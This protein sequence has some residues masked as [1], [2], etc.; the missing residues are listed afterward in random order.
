M[1]VTVLILGGT[2]EARQL[3]CVL[4]ADGVDFLS[5]LAGRVAEPRLP[6]GRVRIGG[7]G[8]AEG[9]AVFLTEYDIRAVVDATHPFAAGMSANAVA[10]CGRVGVPL[11]RLARPG[12]AGLP[13]APRWCW[14]ASHET[15]AVT[16]ASL[17]SR[18]LLTTGRRSLGRYRERLAQHVV[19]ARVV[20][21]VDQQVPPS[22]RVVLDRGPYDVDG[23][24]AL[25]K[26]HRI[27]VLVTKDSGGDYTSAK[28]DAADEFGVRVVVVRRPD[29][30]LD[31]PCVSD[32]AAAMHWLGSRP[33]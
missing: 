7:F 15:A 16:A 2:G 21:P 13:G 27:D 25:L 8:G 30:R 4:A 6:V 31:V 17:G 10:A 26:E 22:W 28:L 24:R 14:V 18:I 12:W 11:V 33:G 3:A 20:E 32:V 23:E 29:A 19:V 9:L 1:S 5:S